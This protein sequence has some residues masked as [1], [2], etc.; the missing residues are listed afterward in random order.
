MASLV[1]QDIV[2]KQ[3]LALLETPCH[4]YLTGSP[5]CGKS[6]L[7]KELLQNYAKEHGRPNVNEWATK[8]TDECLM[9]GPDQD[10]GIQTIRGYVSLF[11][12]QKS[13]RRYFG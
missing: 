10:R 11:I 4:I 2:W 5:G 13:Y 1:G 8:T 3:C 7:V 6:T 12:R 9:L